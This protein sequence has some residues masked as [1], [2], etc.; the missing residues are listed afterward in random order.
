M[1]KMINYNGIEITGWKYLA[2]YAVALKKIARAVSCSVESNEMI[3]L[4]L[5]LRNLLN[6]ISHLLHIH[7]VYSRLF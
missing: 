6:C 7:L 2:L 3:C 5:V 1:R 4:I